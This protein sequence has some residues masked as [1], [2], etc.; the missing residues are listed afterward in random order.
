MALKILSIDGGGIRGI[1][2]G[3]ILVT[4][5]KKLQERSGNPDARLAD[6]FDMF[7]GTSTGAI[8][9]AAYACPG[10][11]G[12]PKFSAEEAVGFYLEE[13]D[14]IFD[15]GIFH[16]IG[17]VG[18]LNDEKYPADDLERVLRD[19]FGDIKLSE[20]TKPTCFVAYDIKKRTQVIFNQIRA[21]KDKDD[22]LVRDLLRGSS[23]APTYFETARVYSCPPKAK[24]YILVDGG[25]VAND[26]AL[27]AYSEA[28]KLKDETGEKRANGLKD[29]MILS[30][31][32]G[33]NLKKYKYSDAKDWGVV[34]WAKPAIDIALEGGPQMTQY[35]MKMIASTVGDS[36]YF[37]IDPELNGA[38]PDLDDVSSENL[39][40]LKKAGDV[41]AEKFDETL[42]AVV[43][44][45]IGPNLT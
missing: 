1:I 41:N 22:F 35:H 34:G 15:A 5:E 24:P 36:S 10:E 40:K 31:G 12:R 23:A 45:L 29:M 11:N 27:C 6:Y 30:I 9:S 3:Q 2:P 18:G 38:S 44:L 7:A 25:L 43:S 20:L 26:P 28:L 19:A 4:L 17:A 33:K 14:E 13:G 8:L 21:G 37:R 39:M 42:N 32:T 16:K